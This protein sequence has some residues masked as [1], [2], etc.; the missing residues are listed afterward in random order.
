MGGGVGVG[1]SETRMTA[2]MLKQD[3]NTQMIK[4]DAT[5]MTIQNLCGFSGDYAP[6]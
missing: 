5:L 3:P 1:G 4:K 2:S 6:F